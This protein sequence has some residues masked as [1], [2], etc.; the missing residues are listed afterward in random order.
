MAD[1]PNKHWV[2]ASDVALRAGVSRSA[3]SRAFSPTASIAPETRERVMR[4]ARALGYQVNLIARDMI[5]QRS[6]MV[7]VVTAGF[8]NPFRAKLL[9]D[10]LTALG[11][12]ALTPLVMNAEDPRQ[13]KHSLEML[14]S[15]RIAGIVM[16]SASPPLRLARQYLDHQ[17]PVAMINRASN[18]PGADV[19][20]SDN[21]AGAA[22]AAR[23]LTRAGARR[24]AFVGP[25]ETSYSALARHAEFARLAP[26]GGLPPVALLDTPADTYASGV[27]A[28]HRLAALDPRPDGVF[29]S[30]DLLALGLI[31]TARH[32]YGLSVPGDLCVIGFDDIP[33]AGYDT[34]Q[35][36]TIQQDTHGLANQ[37]V[38]MLADRIDAYSGDSRTRVVPVTSVVRKTCG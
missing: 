1:K 7:G 35:L 3:V 27:A 9:A 13:I 14:L 17:I 31:D 12:Y 22:H 19:V 24:L 23:L 37:A 26:E 32:H 38:D 16:T 25:V 15:Y 33:A 28:A 5:T 6:S 30:S 18:L 21:A 10:I 8:E 4:A 34:Y 29:C 2:T 36:S 11:R 20:V